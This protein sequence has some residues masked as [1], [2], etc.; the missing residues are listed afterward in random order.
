[1][2]FS[3]SFGKKEEEKGLWDLDSPDSIVNLK[4]P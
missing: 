4:I 2:L 1:M 3:L